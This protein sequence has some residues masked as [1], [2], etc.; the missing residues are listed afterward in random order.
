MPRN[1]S[2]SF[3]KLAKPFAR[4]TRLAIPTLFFLIPL[5]FAP[6]TSEALEMNKQVVMFVGVF[7]AACGWLGNM[8]AERQVRVRGGWILNIIPLIFL[9]VMLV[10]TALSLTGLTAWLGYGG[11]EYMSFLTAAL[12][13]VLFYVLLNDSDTV[14]ARRSLVAL[15]SAASLI[16]LVTLFSL[17]GL[18]LIPFAFTHVVGFN[19]VGNINGFAAWLIPIVIAGLGLYLVD[20]QTG[21]SMIPA[22]V[23]GVMVKVMIAFLTGILLLLLVAIDYWTLWAAF[24]VGLATL[25]FMSFLA[26]KHFPNLRR[27]LVPGVIFFVAVFFLFIKTPVSLKLPVVVSPSVNT[28]WDI[29]TA[30]LGQDATRLL[31]GSG[32]GSY[33]LD[34]ARYHPAEVNNTVFWNTRFDRAQMQPLTILTS[35]GVLGALSWLMLVLVV[36]VYGL[37]RLARDRQESAWQMGY[38][39]MASWSALLTVLLL[40]PANMSQIV[41]FWGLSG[42]VVGESAIKS[43]VW[44]FQ[45]APRSALA[46]TGAFVLFT[47]AGVL[48]LFVLVSRETADM[49]FVK[50]ARLNNAGVDPQ[51]L[52]D[53]M[54]QAVARDGSN[55]VYA[56][57]LATAYLAQASKIVSDGLA[58]D[59][60]SAEEK[61]ALALAANSAIKSASLAVKLG[62]YDGLNWSTNGLIYREL[63]PFLPNAQNY[64]ASTYLKALE[65]EPSNA[66]Y[67]TDLGRVYLA[68]ADRA[69]EVQNLKDVD[70]DTK[71]IAE[72]NETEDLRLAAE[73]LEQAVRLKPDYAPAHYY[74]AATYER[75]GNLEDASKRLA[76]LTQVHPDDVGLGFQL[77]VIY[78]KMDKQA[79]AKTEL[80]RILVIYP[81]YSNAMWYLAAI[82]ANERDVDGALDLLRRVLKLNPDNTVVAESIKNLETGGATPTVPEPIAPIVEEVAP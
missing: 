65:L 16:G 4:L 6:F 43:R 14:L 41:L 40:T 73:A 24:M 15:L 64:A 81:D 36:A 39:L 67:Q 35:N 17:F 20:D 10:S 68:V 75:Q 26:P 70:D 30:T 22:G 21:Q 62:S 11:Q 1:V 32:P 37:G 33:A 56:R 19:T 57:N 52:V 82:K 50:A 79:E 78:L 63:M 3:E 12:G 31:V 77:S 2:V 72:T 71:A 59:D 44:N 58:D 51:A 60:F 5:A 76:A 13:V 42:L 27:L 69:Q 25:T 53:T 80:E 23:T 48:C 45:V 29:A 66:A 47:V 8:V 28:S 46:V 9:L 61:Q 38:V 49:A 55:P 74:L 34:Y 18:N 54:S 7:L